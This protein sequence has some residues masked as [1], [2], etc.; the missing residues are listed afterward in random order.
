[1]TYRRVEVLNVNI[2]GEHVG[3]VAPSGRGYAFEYT[4][5]WRGRRIEL[6]PALMPT[7]SR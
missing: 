7:V 2:W 6:A 5:A 4:P 1:V 3:A